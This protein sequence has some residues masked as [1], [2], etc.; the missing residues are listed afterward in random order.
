MGANWHHLLRLRTVTC[1]RSLSENRKYAFWLVKIK[2]PVPVLL[3]AAFN[4]PRGVGYSRAETTSVLK[5]IKLWTLF[6]MFDDSL[7]VRDHALRSCE[8]SIQKRSTV[9]GFHSQT[10]NK[11]KKVGVLLPSL[12]L[13]QNN[14]VWILT[15]CLLLKPWLPQYILRFKQLSTSSC[16]S[17]LATTSSFNLPAPERKRRPSKARLHAPIN[18]PM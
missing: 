4:V 8:L 13:R 7:P 5:V 10:W 1:Q 14:I 18:K 11:S 6:S 17:I 2:I 3:I 15:F 12:S 16:E 9:K